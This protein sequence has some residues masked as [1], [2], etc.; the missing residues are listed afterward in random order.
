MLR[1]DQRAGQAGL[2][3]SQGDQGHGKK[4]G[5]RR[6][7]LETDDPQRRADEQAG[8]QDVQAHD[9]AGNDDR[10]QQR[11]AGVGHQ[12]AEAGWNTGHGQSD[13]QRRDQR[14][15]CKHQPRAG[16]A[17]VAPP[18]R[19]GIRS[20]CKRQ[21]LHA[22]HHSQNRQMVNAAGHQRRSSRP[23]YR[24]QAGH[25]AMPAQIE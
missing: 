14:P 6:A 18:S 16:L 13:A 9:Q 19:S 25:A 11:L 10:R 24:D 22:V 17:D 5:H 12:L 1:V 3:R 23:P 15:N 4:E 7:T 20:L 8:Q 21:A 2:G